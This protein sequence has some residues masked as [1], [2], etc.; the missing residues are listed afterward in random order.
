MRSLGGTDDEFNLVRLTA[1]EH[2]LAHLLL[3]R[4]NRCSQT[5]YALWMM[6]CNADTNIGRICIKSSRMYEWARKEFIKYISKN[7]KVTSKGE[8]NSQHGTRWICNIK[9]QENKKILKTDELPYG[10]I[11][12]R[13]KW[14]LSVS[15]PYIRPSGVSVKG[16]KEHRMKQ[17]EKNKISKIGNKSLSGKIWVTDGAIN[18]VIDKNDSYPTGFYKGRAISN[19][20]ERVS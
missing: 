13:N 15:R 2:Y 3:A 9:L 11:L 4:F 14:H 5:S 19:V 12:G 20:D 7:A 1:R 6:Q 18:K 8:R 17:S 16:S 10:W